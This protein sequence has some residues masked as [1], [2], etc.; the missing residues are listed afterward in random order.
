MATAAVAATTALAFGALLRCVPAAERLFNIVPLAPL[1]LALGATATSFPLPPLTVLA[2]AAATTVPVVLVLVT[3]TIRA[4][5]EAAA[6][7]RH[8]LTALFRGAV[9]LVLLA[10]SIDR[11]HLG[12]VVVGRLPPR[13]GESARVGP[14]LPW[15]I[16][17]DASRLIT[18]G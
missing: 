12:L 1:L 5:V 13:P 2:G 10:A 3:L 8:G 11:T 17:F 6:A 7:V 15:L 16:T 9:L 18:F 4:L 14:S